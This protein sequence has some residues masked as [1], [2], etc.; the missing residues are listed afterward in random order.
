MTLIKQIKI[1]GFSII[2]CGLFY[3]QILQGDYFSNKA[4]TNYIRLIPKEAPRGLIFD[5]KERLL[6]KNNLEFQVCVFSHKEKEETFKSIAQIL[7]VDPAK[8]E[9]NFRRNFIAPFIPA[10]VYS[11]TQK[12]EIL[13]LDE[14]NIPQVTVVVRPR[15]YTVFPYRLCHVA[16]FTRKLSKENLFLTKFGYSFQEDI[17]YSGIELTYDN[18]LRGKPGGTQ[19]EIDSKGRLVNLL[20]EKIPQA[21]KD[22]YTTLD[23]EIQGKAL[24]ALGNYKGSLILM[25]SESGKILSIAS[26]PTF[27]VNSFTENKEYFK[28]TMNNRLKPLLNRPLQAEYPLGSVF[29]I[30]VGLAGLNEK[31]IEKNSQFSCNGG[32]QLKL[33]RFKCWS[34]HGLQ[35]IIDALAHS[36]NVFFYNLGLRL[37]PKNMHNY[38]V[39]LGLGKLTEIDLPFE[40]KGFVPTS[41][42]KEKTLND[43]WYP[44]DNLNFS[45]GQGYLTVTPVQVAKL[46]S[47]FATKGYLVQPYLVERISELEIPLRKKEL[48][49]INTANIELINEGLRQAVA[50]QEGTAHILED[51][52]LDIAGKTGTAQVTGKKAHGWFAGFFPYKKP[53]YIIVVMLESASSS[54]R[55]CQITH[56]FLHLVKEENLLEL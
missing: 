37:G 21:G 8:L 30:V 42:W 43:K 11:T 7:K 17:G 10:V 51:L 31:K 3:Y 23:I 53:K 5:R 33:T 19:F 49:N 44:G 35:N 48:I 20:G 14:K 54:Y 28:E 15:R 12:D 18:Y 39:L 1:I 47:F 24:E 46:T 40:K 22:I 38:A 25:E 36:C 32:F 16:G 4:S 56:K 52:K 6:V 26:N 29:K 55:A 9:N 13:K 27:D 41:S 2:L 50:T 34:V 45:I